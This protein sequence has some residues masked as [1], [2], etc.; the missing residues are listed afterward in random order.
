L[1]VTLLDRLFVVAVG[2][3][4]IGA[5]LEGCGDLIELVQHVPDGAAM[6]ERF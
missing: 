3:V 2:A 4:G 1:G 6:Q 5:E